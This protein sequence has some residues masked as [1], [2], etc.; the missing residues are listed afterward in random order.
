MKLSNNPFYA[1][2]VCTLHNDIW[3]KRQRIAGKVAAQTLSLLESLVEEK[4]VK[5]LSELDK[6]AEEFILSKG[7]TPTFKNYKGFP[8]SVCMSLNNVLVHGI[9]FDYKLQD[10]DS[11]SFDTGATYVGAI[12]DTALSCIFGQPKLEQHISLIQDTRDALMKSIQMIKIGDRI[13]SIG[14][15]IYKHLA[16]KGYGVISNYGGH[17]MLTN[18]PHAFPF[19]SNKANINEGIRIQPGIVLCIE[20]MATLNGTTKTWTGTDGWSVFTESASSHE[21]HTIFVHEDGKIELITD[22]S[23]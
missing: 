21:E 3:L 6:I 12:G 13:G 7:C 16:P 2:D 4:T 11:I 18:T 9:P 17:S 10:G 20:P 23:N 5:S 22:R 1:G 8:A 14:N 19:V 15:T